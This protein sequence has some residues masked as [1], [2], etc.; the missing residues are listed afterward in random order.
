MGS[1]TKIKRSTRQAT[2]KDHELFL[3]E[4][5]QGLP[6]EFP[7]KVVCSRKPLTEERQSHL[8]SDSEFLRT[9]AKLVEKGVKKIPAL[10]EKIEDFDL[11][12]QHEE[13]VSTMLAPIYPNRAR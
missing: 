11:L 10:A 5:D 1:F 7:L 4:I 3:N 13:I 9:T 2:F 8:D 6:S 12:I